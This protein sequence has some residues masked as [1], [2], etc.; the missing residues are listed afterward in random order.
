VSPVPYGIARLRPEPSQ[1]EQVMNSKTLDQMHTWMRCYQP[2]PH[3]R[4]QLVCFPPE[5]A[6]AG[7]YRSWCCRLP[8]TVELLAVQYPGR[9][10][11]LHEACIDDMQLLAD[12]TTDALGVVTPK[13][14]VLFGHGLGALLAFEVA[15]RLEKRLAVG[16]VRLFVSG[17]APCREPDH[18]R[19]SIADQTSP[20]GPY[21]LTRCAQEFMNDAAKSPALRSDCRISAAYQPGADAKL[22]SPI[23]AY[24]GIDDSMVSM[25]QV[26]R[27]SHFTWGDFRARSFPG[28]QFY[29]KQNSGMV[30]AELL[31]SL[32][33]ADKN[34]AVWPA[35]S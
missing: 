32:H 1:D 2:R 25:D 11:R 20:I 34:P 7:F 26:R 33:L 4:V 35:A 18:I 17:R 3:A 16:A 29:L 13:A 14:L 23:A 24:V 10:D 15:L 5:G 21:E 9:E 30:V 6:S 27:W 31:R 19:S 12:R 22:R 8:V 28:G